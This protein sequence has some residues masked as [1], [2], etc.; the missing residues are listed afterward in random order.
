MAFDNILTCFQ[1]ICTERGY[2]TKGS[3]QNIEFSRQNVLNNLLPSDLFAP[4]I[5]LKI[6]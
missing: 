2:L 5:K 3:L 4:N 6:F 1:Y